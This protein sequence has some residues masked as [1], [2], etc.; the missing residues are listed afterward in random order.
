ML[1]YTIKSITKSLLK[2]GRYTFHV[3]R[4]QCSEVELKERL[5]VQHK[6]V[7]KWA[8]N[9]YRNSFLKFEKQEFHL[10]SDVGETPPNL[11]KINLFSAFVVLTLHYLMTVVA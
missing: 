2:L 5:V 8:H 9:D 7:D 11:Q 4:F 1:L 6:T 3:A 10:I